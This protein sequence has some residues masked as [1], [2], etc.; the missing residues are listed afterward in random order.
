MREEKSH[1]RFESNN[2]A[3]NVNGDFCR[4]K[5]FGLRFMRSG[6]ECVPIWFPSSRAVKGAR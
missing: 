4:L 3:A 5:A 6:V 1:P 2:L